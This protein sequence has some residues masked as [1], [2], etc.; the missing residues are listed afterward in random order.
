VRNMVWVG[1]GVWLSIR[2]DSTIRLYHAHTYQHLQDVDIE[3]YITTMLG[4]NKLDFLHLRI[5]SLLVLNRRLWIGS[6]TGVIVSVPLSEEDA[7]KVDMAASAIMSSSAAKNSEEVRGPGGLIRVYGNPNSERVSPGSFIPYC[8][9]AHAQLSF[10]GHK[11]SVRFFCPV[12]ADSNPALLR[13]METRKILMVSGGDGYID[14]RL[15]EE[16]DPP[17]VAADQV[18]VHDMSH[19]IVWELE[20]PNLSKKS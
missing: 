4:S 9:M 17:P 10:H 1:D 20:V 14:F 18:R 5:T 13:E 12:P 11:D 19:L 16:E 8:N 15:G 6:G 3:P 2:L 7:S